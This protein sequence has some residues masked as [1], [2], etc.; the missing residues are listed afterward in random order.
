VLCSLAFSGEAFG[1]D[2]SPFQE[3]N[4]IKFEIIKVRD[5]SAYLIDGPERLAILGNIKQT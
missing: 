2:V 3:S 5:N 4:T 1:A